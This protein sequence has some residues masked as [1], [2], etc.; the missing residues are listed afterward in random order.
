MKDDFYKDM[1]HKR[2]QDEKSSK[3][4]SQNKKSQPKKRETL[5]RSARHKPKETPDSKVTTKQ[6]TKAKSKSSSNPN[7]KSKTN[8]KQQKQQPD[9]N[10]I[11]N[12]LKGYFSAENAAKGKAFFA[13]KFS[14]YQNRIKDELKMS[15][16]KLGSIGTAKTAGAKKENNADGAS[17]RKLPWVLS[18]IVLI[19]ITVLFAFLIFS[20][21][22]PSL[23]DEIQVADENTAE[24]TAAGD[25]EENN[26]EEQSA[27]LA[28]QKAEHEKRLSENRN[29][30]LTSQELENNYS[31]AELQEL[32]EASLS[33]IRSKE[34]EPAEST[35]NPADTEESSEEDTTSEEA[36]DDAEAPETAP[37][38]EENTAG[39]SSESD[40]PDANTTHTVT[41]TDNVYQ[42]ALRYYGDG[43]AENVQRIL[44]ANGMSDDNISVGQELIIP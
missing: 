13:G 14:T 30:D 36:P 38:T 22:W 24:E 3:T 15:K 23:D 33:A 5:S 37:E 12:K 17:K 1:N 44:A 9:E 40:S 32:E 4:D 6:H 18:L 43:S 25:E 20:N 42:I 11:T 21:F 7:A 2:A 34:D 10:N 19:P 39:E 28:A 31:Q 29:E 35:E 26:E 41:S 8:V 16:E 27:E